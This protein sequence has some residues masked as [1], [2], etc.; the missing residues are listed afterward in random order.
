[1]WD[2]KTDN[3]HVSKTYPRSRHHHEETYREEWE[4]VAM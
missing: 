1:M 3:V 2:V 4:G